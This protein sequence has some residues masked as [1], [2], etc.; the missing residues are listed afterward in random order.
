[1][2]ER[3]LNLDRGHILAARDDD[4]L[5]AVSDLNIGIGVLHGDIA[6]VEIPASEGLGRGLRVLVIAFHGRVAPHH[7]L[8]QGCSIHRD[9]GHGFGLHHG[10]V[11]H[12]GHGNPLARLDGRA[13]RSL[14][15][16]PD[17]IL[18]SAFGCGAIDLGQ[19]IDLG[20]VKTHCLDRGQGGGG[21]GRA[22]SKDLDDM[23]EAAA[24]LRLCV[25][26]HVQHNRCAAKMGHALIGDGVI[27]GLG[28]DVTAA[29]G[30]A[31]H[32]RHGPDM[33]PIVAMEQR[34]DCQVD[35]IERHAPRNRR[36]HGDQIGPA[37]MINHAFGPPRRA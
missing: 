17:I 13:T 8:A 26:Q 27:D 18:P 2:H 37:M 20:D 25:D 30:G 9:L 14:Q 34:H 21:R 19:T 1:M 33:A 22:C 24:L 35:R 32:H 16:T 7:D 6:G 5:G 29:H 10:D 11:V 15:I 28:G 36:A 23:V 12:I 4:I 31:A 3:A